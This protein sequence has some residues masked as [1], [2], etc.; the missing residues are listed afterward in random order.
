VVN[1]AFPPATVF[2]CSFNNAIRYG[3]KI[4]Q[5]ARRK[6]VQPTCFLSSFLRVISAALSSLLIPAKLGVTGVDTGLFFVMSDQPSDSGGGAGGEEIGVETW[7]EL[8]DMARL[9][10]AI[11]SFCG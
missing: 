8:M 7:L 10:G 2:F 5:Y 3:K 1:Q 4:S 11:D 6:E 9:F